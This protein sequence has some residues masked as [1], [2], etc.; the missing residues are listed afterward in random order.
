VPL[1]FLTIG[2]L[3]LPLHCI[4]MRFPCIMNHPFRV[5]LM[6]LGLDQGRVSQHRRL[7]S[8]WA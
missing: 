8:F 5:G 1:L 6:V 2:V 4:G 3:D 7:E